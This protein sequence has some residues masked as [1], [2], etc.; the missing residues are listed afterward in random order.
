M[1]IYNPHSKLD[2]YSND[3]EY[4]SKTK[5]IEKPTM[6]DRSKSIKTKTKSKMIL[7]NKIEQ[8]SISIHIQRFKNT[9]L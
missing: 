3:S 5:S 1:E 7:R 4:Y 6:I 8:K 2:Q 9:G